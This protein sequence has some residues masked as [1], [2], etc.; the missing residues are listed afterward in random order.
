MT[1]HLKH[2]IPEDVLPPILKQLEAMG[3]DFYLCGSRY[4]FR[5]LKEN[6]IDIGWHLLMDEP[7]PVLDESTDWDFATEL[8]PS[9]EMALLDLG[10]VGAEVYTLDECTSS[11]LEH[12][13]EA[14]NKVQISIRYNVE[15]YHTILDTIGVNFYL[16]YLWKSN[17]EYDISHKQIG[18][19][20]TMLNRAVDAGRKLGNPRVIH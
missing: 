18:D 14:G 20:L 8:T 6:E 3:V 1:I 2:I 13:D 5:P 4:F 16:D 11:V 19:I 15:N 17:P 7:I 12:I 9:I 10:F